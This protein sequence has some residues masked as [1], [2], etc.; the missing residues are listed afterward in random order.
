M[1]LMLPV[2][3]VTYV[4]QDKYYFGIGGKK[5]LNHKGEECITI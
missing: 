1:H 4:Y 3:L 2:D 5:F